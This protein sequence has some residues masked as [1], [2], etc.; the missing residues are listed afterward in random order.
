MHPINRRQ[1]GWNLG[2]ALGAAALASAGLGARA[3]T[4]TPRILVGFPAGGSVDATARRLAETWRP[5]LGTVVVEQKVGAGGRIAVTTLRDA[6][7]DGLTMLLSPSSMFTIYP[8]VFKRLQ[9]KPATDAIAV[10]P[11]ALSTC[12]FMVVPKVPESVRT[13]RQFADWAKAQPEPQGYASPAAGAMPHFLGNQ[14]ARA[15]GVAL[16]H[17]P[18][19]GAAPGLQDLMGG[20][21]A[22]GCFSVG[23]CLP[24]L[25]SGRVRVLGV[26]DARRSRFLPEVPTFEEQGV[27]GAS[28]SE[29]FAF[30]LPPKANADVVARMNA[31]L[32][33]ALAAPDVVEG[34]AGFGLEAMSSSPAE[35]AEL[36]KRDTAKWGPIVKQIGF[37]AEG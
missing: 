26:T 14:F 10:S 7:P 27:K 21:V 30:L 6:A 1:L 34:L 17:L 25:P 36:L 15:A 9:Y 13:L 20:Q 28:H 3:Q 32:K 16:T 23:D 31:A 2:R 11:V 18:Y 24:H 33:T 19:R 29:W 22:S 35:L 4:G 37:T 5:R 12:G 8:H